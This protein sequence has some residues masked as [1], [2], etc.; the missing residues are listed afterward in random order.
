MPSSATPTSSVFFKGARC[1]VA[2][3][4]LAAPPLSAEPTSTEVEG[5]A[6]A[7]SGGYTGLNAS[8]D[9]E[10]QRDDV[11]PYGRLEL[12]TDSFVR[13]LSAFGG[14]SKDWDGGWTGRAGLGLIGGR[15]QEAS[16]DGSAAGLE[17]GLEK[18][19]G[20]GALGAEY[21]Y[22]T[23]TIGG[24][25]A[26]P[27]FGRSLLTRGRSGRPPGR[28]GSASMAG[29]PAPYDYNEASAYA[30][31]RL[32]PGLAEAR[33]DVGSPSY[34]GTARTETLSYKWPPGGTWSIKVSVAFEQGSSTGTFAGAGLVLRFQ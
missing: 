10:W 26:S 33:L 23:G 14:V 12:Q 9:L 29:T 5:T 2:V 32:G 27:G 18:A 13:E 6:S 19:L 15:L 24:P 30:N 28:G 7:G 22:T 1:L 20:R 4:I 34:A 17:L 8:A 21:R 25:A 16:D 31:A 3:L 11:S